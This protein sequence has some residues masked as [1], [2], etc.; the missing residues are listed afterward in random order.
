MEPNRASSTPRTCPRPFALSLLPANIRGTKRSNCSASRSGLPDGRAQGRRPRTR[1]PWSDL[2]NRDAPV[3]IVGL[4]IVAPRFMAW[5]AASDGRRRAGAGK[6]ARYQ[7]LLPAGCRILKESHPRS[8]LKS[9]MGRFE[10]CEVDRRWIS[11]DG[12]PLQAIAIVCAARAHGLMRTQRPPRS[13][14]SRRQRGSLPMRLVG[15]RKRHRSR[16]RSHHSL[17]SAP[18]HV[19]CCQA[20]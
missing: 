7:R 16:R 8:Q 4:F 19:L 20:Q 2:R 14:H 9:A 10:R 6:A 17:E 18:P 5:I 13:L 3:S 11:S 15:L 12:L 1:R